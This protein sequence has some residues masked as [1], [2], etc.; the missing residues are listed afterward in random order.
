MTRATLNHWGP[1]TEYRSERVG[2]F[3][4]ILE[5]SVE[6]TSKWVSLGSTDPTDDTPHRRMVWYHRG[7]STGIKVVDRFPAGIGWLAHPEER[8][9]R[10]SHALVGDDGV[11]I[12]DP[13]DAPRTDELLADLGSVVGVAVLSDYHARD[14]ATFAQRYDVPVSVPSWFRRVPRKVDVPLQTIESELGESGIEIRRYTPFPLWR[15]GIAVHKDLGTLYVPE[16]LSTLDSY[17]VDPERVGLH[18]ATRLIPPRRVLGE[19]EPDRLL[20]GH[21][22]GIFENATAALAETLGGGRKRFLAALWDHGLTRLHATLHGAL[23]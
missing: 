7:S 4:G 15:E 11:W 16:C 17:R 21:G 10:V 12:V 14:A 3:R 8:G 9:Q 22:C 20:C 5:I 2:W 19:L 1:V 23:H 13:L 6:A 18:T